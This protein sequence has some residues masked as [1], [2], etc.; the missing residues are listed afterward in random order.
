MTVKN[1]QK[2]SVLDAMKERRLFFDGG[3]GTMLVGAGLRAGEPP[4]I[5]NARCPDA[6]RELHR[7]YIKAGADIIKTNTFGISPQKYA[8]YREMLAGAVA[9]A[10]AAVNESGRECYI[11]LDIGPLDRMIE[12]VGEMKQEEAI[13]QFRAIAEEGERLGCDLVLIETMSDLAQ[14]KAA[15]LG[16][17]EGSS[18]PV[19]VTCA[20]GE[21]G[22]LLTGADPEAFVAM[23]EGLG[24]D[25]VGI[26]CSVGPYQ[27]RETVTR[28]VRAASVGVVVNPNA[29]MPRVENGEAVYDLGAEEF[30]SV[31]RE[32]VSLGA[33]VVGGCCGTTPDYI[34]ALRSALEGVEYTLPQK[35]SN[36][37]VCSYCR[38]VDIGGGVPV[39]VGERINPTGKPKL[40]A[41]LRE[42]DLSYLVSEALAEEEEG[43]HILDVNTGLADID[44]AVMLVRA[45]RE[46]QAVCPLPIQIDTGNITAL[47]G[48][49]RAYVGKPVVNS[50]NGTAQSMSSVLP[51]VKKY[52]GVV[53]AL[54]MDEHGIPEDAMGRVEIAERI[55]AEAVK[56]GLQK[57]DIV[58]DPLVLT[59]A[60][61]KDNALVTLEALRI[62]RD[63][64]FKTSLGV[65]NISFGLPQ[66]DVI[67]SAFF[68][69]ALWSG[70]SMA[71]INPHSPQMMNAYLS[72]FALSGI[73]DGCVGY[74]DSVRALVGEQ[75]QTAKAKT[76]TPMTLG[77][78]IEKGLGDVARQECERALETADAMEIVNGEIIPALDRV[79]A[80]FESKRIFLP[81]LMRAA[82]AASAA[83]GL[84][85]ERASRSSDNGITVLLATVQGDIHDIGKNIVKLMFE[86]YGYRVI[87]LGRDVAPE[88]IIEVLTTE[89]VDILG[90]SALMTTTLPAMK[91]TVELARAKYP[92]L[93]IIVGGA[94]LT[95]TYADSIGAEYAPDAIT[96]IRLAEK[97][98]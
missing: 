49:M 84:I 19:F 35:K 70:L 15:L 2:K 91:T 90:L 14:V 80:G 96:A 97:L 36:A 76:E 26:N 17:K 46:I 45:V 67:T 27:M 21:D 62:L 10:R 66:R 77:Y 37:V 42:G 59:V 33:T 55:C 16:V 22:K 32:L 51:L 6:V 72:Y 11:A 40:K 94:V 28:F 23:A 9:L 13:A 18:L 43:A 92:N 7:A 41:A 75:T 87:D 89:H 93:K 57:S 82:E 54:T 24:A 52:G 73:D 95:Q 5:M 31:V 30:A 85:K 34:R 8:D 71:I 98:L 63:R 29:G 65:S 78:A 69:A 79:G 38:A 58:V 39:V 48:A 50:V 44:E 25:A 47:E 3:T 1:K 74:I 88:R 83:F 53:I 81:T 4:E 12:P 61:G 68:T 86:S 60:S 64:G 20:F 56:Y